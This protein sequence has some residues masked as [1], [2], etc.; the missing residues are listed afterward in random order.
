MTIYRHILLIACAVLAVEVHAAGLYL[1]TKKVTRSQYYTGT[2]GAARIDS[3]NY[4][5]WISANADNVADLGIRN[6]GFVIPDAEL[7]TLLYGI[8][9]RLLAHWPGTA[10]P[11]VIYVQGD[12]SPLSY[13]AQTTYFG[14]IFIDYGV[15]KHAESEDELAAVIG[16]ELAHVLLGHGKAL[17]YRQNIQKSLDTITQARELYAQAEALEYNEASET[18]SIDPSAE[19]KIRQSAMQ[20]VIADRF[21]NSAHATLFSRGSEHEADRLALDLLV[22]A[23]YSPAGI[24]ASLE[25]MAHAHNLSTQISGYLTTSSQEMLE[26][27]MNEVMT[28]LEQSDA[29]DLDEYF[30]DSS[31]V[32]KDSALEFGKNAFINFTAR[33]HPVPEKRVKQIT[34]YLYDNYSRSVRRRQPDPASAEAFK[35]GHIAALIGQYE[36][37]NQAIQAIGLGEFDI[38]QER[39]AAAL[40]PAADEH[41]Y[42]RYV[43][44]VTDRTNSSS[45]AAAAHIGKMDTQQPI[46]LFA[47]TEVAEFLVGTGQTVQAEALISRFESLFGPVNEFYPPKISLAVA[48]NDS[49]RVDEYT[50][51]CFAVTSPDSPLSDKCATASGISRIV[52]TT[53][54]EAEAEEA[55]DSL[56]GFLKSLSE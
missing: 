41:P 46:P 29:S 35:S 6:Q 50:Q 48:A 43:A 7:N 45:D 21:Y 11:I 31:D 27:S 42:F 44:F 38:A 20:K 16:H 13:G 37:A 47:S 8:A 51:A 1:D 49:A 33:S 54:E 25:R 10:P 56:G 15:L 5:Q 30:E 14:E 53:T 26:A 22:A 34:D 40:G 12:R 19:K 55:M 2:P 17:K 28:A 39:A 52:S 3:I 4:E 36:A 24:K 32:W 9:N 18:F 23:G